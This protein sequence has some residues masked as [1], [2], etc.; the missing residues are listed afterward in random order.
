VHVKASCVT[1][2]TAR[3][4]YCRQIEARV[5]KLQESPRSV[6]FEAKLDFDGPLTSCLLGSA[7][8]WRNF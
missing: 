6:S 1:S 4:S 5:A 3:T 8:T 2:G 7:K